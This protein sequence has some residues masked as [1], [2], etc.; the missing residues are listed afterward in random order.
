MFG[1]YHDIDEYMPDSGYKSVYSPAQKKDSFNCMKVK[2][3]NKSIVLSLNQVVC[4]ATLN[5][6]NKSLG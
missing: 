2:V 1:C 5:A 6:V 4:A 3:R